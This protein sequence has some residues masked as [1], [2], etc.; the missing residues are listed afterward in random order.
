MVELFNRQTGQFEPA[1]IVSPVEG[2]DTLCFANNWLPAF[3]QKEAE[4]RAAG[5]FDAEG[6]AN[7]N[8]EDFHWKWKQKIAAR[9][10]ELRWACHALRCGGKVQGLMFTDTVRHCRHPSHLNEHMVYIDLLATAPWNRPRF[11]PTPQYRGIGLVLL[12]EAI[13]QS[14]Q[15]G[16]GGRLGLHSLPGADAFY[17]DQI[18][19]L[20]LGPDPQ[21]DG[22]RYFEMTSDL[23]DAFLNP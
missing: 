23:A 11:T 1:E 7:S 9:R 17:R 12:T 15:E 14:R 3:A 2:V 19:M 22:L 16:F 4:L 10:Q 21:Y 20:D 6:V 5:K 18:K 13:L 8:L